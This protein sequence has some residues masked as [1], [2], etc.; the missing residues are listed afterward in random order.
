MSDRSPEVSFDAFGPSEPQSHFV[1]DDCEPDG[2][3][4]E[5]EASE[6]ARVIDPPE[7]FAAAV[8]AARA[9]HEQVYDPPRDGLVGEHAVRPNL[10]GDAPTYSRVDRPKG[11]NV[12]PK[13]RFPIAV[14]WGS[15][16]GG[17]G[18]VC[19]IIGT[20][21]DG[22]V[23]RCTCEAAL[24]GSRECWAMAATRGLLYVVEED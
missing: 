16:T 7:P 8:D 23:L 14:I 15:A 3:R 13:P 12:T 22:A 17:S 6:G 24:L 21:A 11:K 10:D 5:T 19:A 2:H 18:H 20:N 1:G 4:A 9:H